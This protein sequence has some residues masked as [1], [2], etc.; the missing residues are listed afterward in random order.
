MKILGF[1]IT[2]VK[3]VQPPTHIHVDG[4]VKGLTVHDCRHIIDVMLS[5][6][7]INVHQL[8]LDNVDFEILK[9]ISSLPVSPT[10]EDLLDFRLYSETK[11]EMG[12]L[13]D[14]IMSELKANIAEVEVEDE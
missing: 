14:R 3:K 13:Y 7:F 2:R 4:K 1:E 11:R 12:R 6:D 10:T 8:M 9:S 5:D